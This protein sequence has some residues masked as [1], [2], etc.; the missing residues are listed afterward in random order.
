MNIKL[1]R[2]LVGVGILRVTAALHSNIKARP[3]SALF[4]SYDFY[5]VSPSLQENICG[6][7]EEKNTAKAIQDLRVFSNMSNLRRGLKLQAENLENKTI[8]N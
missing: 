5:A 6:E 8:N 2:L 7:M 4:T 1:I 3:S